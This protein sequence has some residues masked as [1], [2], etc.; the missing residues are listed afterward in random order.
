MIIG[1][2]LRALRE[3]KNLSQESAT[4]FYCG[5]DAA[6]SI[7]SCSGAR[8]RKCRTMATWRGVR[9]QSVSS[10]NICS[11]PE[12]SARGRFLSG[13]RGRLDAVTSVQFVTV[14]SSRSFAVRISPFA[15]CTSSLRRGFRVRLSRT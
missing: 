11:D 13:D 4:F 2:R 12:T 9:P 3:Q 14:T 10:S 6:S 5:C 8:G 1:D 15:L 7:D